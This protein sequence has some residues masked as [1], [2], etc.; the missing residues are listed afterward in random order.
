MSEEQIGVGGVESGEMVRLEAQP[1]RVVSADGGRRY[2]CVFVT[3]GRVRRR[4]GLPSTWVIRPDALRGA[5]PL[6]DEV[7]VF[8][9]HPGLWEGR[10]V[11]DV[12]GVTERGARMV[13]D[14][15]QGVIRF[16]T[17]EAGQFC[18]ELFDYILVEREA[19]REVPDVGLSAVFWHRGEEVD[20]DYVTT[21]F[22]KVESVDVVFGPGAKGAVR[23]ALQAVEGRAVSADRQ[24]Q[25]QPLEGRVQDQPLQE[26][27]AMPQGG[28]IM[29]EELVT[30]QEPVGGGD[31]APPVVAPVAPAVRQVAPAPTA[32]VF[33]GWS[34]EQMASLQRSQQQAQG[35]LVSQCKTFLDAQLHMLTGVLPQA[36]LDHI[37]KQFQGRVFAAHELEAAVED[38]R[39]LLAQLTQAGV[40]RGMGVITD[41]RMLNDMDQV[42]LA[43]E[44]LMG[45]DV[46]EPVRPLTGIKELYIMLTGD[47]QM[48]GVYNAEYAM[49]QSTTMA[50]MAEVTRNVLNKV[51]MDQW[52][53]LGAAGYNWWE[54]VCHLEDFQTLQTVS[55]VKVDGFSNLAAVAEGAAYVEIVWDD[56]RETSDWTKRGGYVGLTL[57][58]IDTDD[59]SAWRAV[60]RGLATAGIR[61]LS[62]AVAALFTANAGTG[63]AL[64]DGFAF[65]DAVNHLNLITQFLDP[66]NYDTAV[67]TMFSQTE[68]G[69]GLRLG[70]KPKYL[71]VPIE[72]EKRGLQIF[73]SAVEPIENASYL[74]VRAS[75]RENVVTVPEWTDEDDWAV[76]ADPVICPSIGVGFRWGRVPE[77]FTVT[78]P[79]MGL[80]FTNDT[81]PIKVRYVYAVG[82]IDYRGAVKSNA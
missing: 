13:G 20:D 33:D 47:R 35:L 80:M 63:P 31:G 11:R 21:E 32:P 75:Q 14:E 3:A 6:F 45:L 60:P 82:V 69:S 74:N 23:A 79:R 42:Q 72:Q 53:K 1:L 62:A 7:A 51:L 34:P 4:D 37:R 65:F 54:R 22:I 71:L 15:L 49:L 26:T 64:A 28:S 57:E 36:S 46:K 66:D 55:W 41:D 9:D 25:G 58:M 73:S 67:Q 38:Q 17:L 10:K 43:Y 30:S 77:L 8:V 16:N 12:G 81:L 27:G 5:E 24:A 70:I 18:A 61:T 48:R 68:Q 56:E 78:D 29:S 59:V 44:K 2:D 19:G 40:V 39:G 52:I 50:A 76:M